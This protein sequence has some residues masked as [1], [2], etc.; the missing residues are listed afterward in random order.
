MRFLHPTHPDPTAQQRGQRFLTLA[1]CMAL[2]GSGAVIAP[3][4]TIVALKMGATPFYIGALNAVHLCNL[5]MQLL[6]MPLVQRYG[7]KVILISW[8]TVTALS[9]VP[10]LALP[11]VAAHLDPAWALTFFMVA[12]AIRHMSRG[13]A[14]TGWMPL[15]QDN[16]PEDHRGRFFGRLRTFSQIMLLL[17]LVAIGLMVGDDTPWAVIRIVFGI[18]V[19]GAIGFILCVLPVKEMA[20]PGTK[21]SLW[22][23]INAPFR[24]RQF[25]WA[26]FYQFS[27]S[28]A[29]GLAD[30]FRI[31]YLDQLGYN[32]RFLLFGP[33]TLY[34]GGILTLSQW[35]K[36]ADRAGNRSVFSICNVGMMI[37]LVGWLLVDNGPIGLTIAIVLFG[38]IGIFNG[39][40]SIAITRYFFS[41]IK[42]DQQA[43][44]VTM[45]SVMSVGT[46]G[47]AGF[48]GG[49]FLN[50]TETLELHQGA[51]TLGPYQVLFLMSAL[52]LCV[53]HMIRT[54]LRRGDE[55]P[56]AEIIA[57][58]T[59]P[60]R[61]VL[62]T[63]ATVA[64]NDRK[65]N[66]SESENQPPNERDLD[67]D[68]R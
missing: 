17:W 5:S 36:L 37:C 49:A 48:I 40:Q 20:P 64:R 52:L 7:K 14:L 39:G 59:R 1:A 61:M 35:G 50:W 22:Q 53:P 65:R 2:V 62:G 16:V 24:D 4:S 67:H 29:F 31:V 58:V 9:L 54:R 57:F 28:F 26:L 12:V 47:A 42:R 18:S 68:E 21:I 44:Y 56:S 11:E 23:M 6:M 55:T 32:D 38:L 8:S 60:L 43:S 41:I 30:P 25:R 10:L 45:W 51:F 13:L 66:I 63:V 27:Y 33:A 46:I 15:F 19:A 3:F 34:V